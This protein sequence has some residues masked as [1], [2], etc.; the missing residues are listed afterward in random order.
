WKVLP[1]ENPNEYIYECSVVLD[2][3]PMVV[4]LSPVS[5]PYG[6]PL[7]EIVPPENDIPEVLKSFNTTIFTFQKMQPVSLFDYQNQQEIG[8][9][10]LE[11]TK[12]RE[13]LQ[14]INV[15]F[16]SVSVSYLTEKKKL[17]LKVKNFNRKNATLT[18]LFEEDEE[19][20]V[21]IQSDCILV[22]PSQ[23]K[24]PKVYR[25]IY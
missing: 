4:R 5:C 18:V 9:Y 8:I 10:E 6:M 23:T 3:A 17:P 22:T 24:R 1:G 16:D 12:K 19:A 7:A 25:K 14:V 13:F 20:L 15:N 2:N 11:F 21:Q